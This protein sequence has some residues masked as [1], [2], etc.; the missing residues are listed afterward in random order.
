MTKG[1]VFT[2]LPPLVVFL[3]LT[4]PSAASVAELAADGSQLN[5]K[6][7][8]VNTL[9]FAATEPPA[10]YSHVADLNFYVTG[11]HFLSYGEIATEVRRAQGKFDGCRIFLRIASLNFIAA[12]PLLSEWESLEFNNGLTEWERELFSQTPPFSAGVV[13]VHNLDWTIGRNGVTAVGYGGYIETETEY[14]ATPQERAFFRERV[15]GHAVLGR[16]AGR[17]SLA[18]ELGHAVMGLR[19]KQSDR[20][21]IMFSGQLARGEDPAFDAAQCEQGRANRPW[22]RPARPTPASLAAADREG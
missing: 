9:R 10:R 19:H 1:P 5:G 2:G 22:V 21:N 17:W 3:C 12:P 16:S 7:R 13:Y 4:L 8:V 11:A 18:H 14:L 6:V 20:N 15:A